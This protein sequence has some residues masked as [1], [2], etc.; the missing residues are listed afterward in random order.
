MPLKSYLAF[1]RLNQRDT[2]AEI[3]SQMPHCQ[4]IP[5]SNR[6]VIVLVTDT[7]DE[8]SEKSLEESFQAIDTLQFLSLVAGAAE[9]EALT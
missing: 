7:P 8:A 5:A 9:P 4:A 6:E 3:L 1:P 2:L